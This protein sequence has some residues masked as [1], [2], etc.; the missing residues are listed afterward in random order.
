MLDFTKCEVCGKL[1]LH[2]Y[3]HDELTGKDFKI[4][5][6]CDTKSEVVK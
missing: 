4:C 5:L 3:F 2:E 6:K 1:K